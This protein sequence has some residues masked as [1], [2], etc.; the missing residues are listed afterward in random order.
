[1]LLQTLA[2]CL[3][4]GGLEWALKIIHYGRLTDK[5]QH[6][7]IQWIVPCAQTTKPVSSTKVAAL[8]KSS[9]NR[10]LA[11]QRLKALC[12]KQSESKEYTMAGPWALDTANSD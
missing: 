2:G 1:M 4:K 11:L 5:G 10:D 7:S 3:R 8:E 6:S 9:A 12:D